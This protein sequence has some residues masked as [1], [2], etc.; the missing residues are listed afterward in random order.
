MA[1]VTSFF[2]SVSSAFISGLKKQFE[3]VRTPV[4]G[5]SFVFP[6]DVGRSM[7]GVRRSRAKPGFPR[8]V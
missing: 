5:P 6:F 3:N 8:Y 4:R 2:I 1:D 7:L